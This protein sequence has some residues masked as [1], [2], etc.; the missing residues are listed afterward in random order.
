MKQASDT[1][2]FPPISIY[3]DGNT[4][5]KTGDTIIFWELYLYDKPDVLGDLKVLWKCEA[6]LT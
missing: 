6:K 5:V 1:D 2:L 4:V 3:V